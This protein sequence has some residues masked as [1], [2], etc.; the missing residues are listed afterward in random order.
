MFYQY[1]ISRKCYIHGALDWG[2]GERTGKMPLGGGPASFQPL[3]LLLSQIR[4]KRNLGVGSSPIK[5]DPPPHLSQLTHQM[6][7]DIEMLL[8]QGLSFAAAK[9]V[10]LKEVVIRLI[11]KAGMNTQSS[12]LIW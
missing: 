2:S 9:R 1:Y 7:E 8:G 5:I 4:R 6:L 11:K 3:F 12:Q 10:A